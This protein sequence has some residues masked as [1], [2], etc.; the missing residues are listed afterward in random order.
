MGR[1]DI[2]LCDGREAGWPEMNIP[3][4]HSADL[5]KIKDFVKRV[6]TFDCHGRLYFRI[7]L[8]KTV[9]HCDSTWLNIPIMAMTTRDRFCIEYYA[10]FK[11][12]APICLADE[13]TWAAFSNHIGALSEVTE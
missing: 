4:T 12:N 3:D 6:G 13:A 8:K 10:V 9:H 7:F 1:R 5:S 11:R 2:D